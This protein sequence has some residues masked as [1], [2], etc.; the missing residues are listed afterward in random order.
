MEY[1]KY[2]AEKMPLKWPYPV[3]YEKETREECDVLVIG[4]GMAGSFAAINAAKKR[5]ER[6]RHR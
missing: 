5:R 3:A 1:R 6:D 2:L 4:G